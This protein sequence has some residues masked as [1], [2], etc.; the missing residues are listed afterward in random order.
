M[1][2]LSPPPLFPSFGW[3]LV[4]DA[5]LISH[6]TDCFF[7]NLDSIETS[8]SA[9]PSPQSTNFEPTVRGDIDITTGVVKKLNHNASERDRRK[10][11]NNLYSSL[12]SLLP[13]AD[14]MK[15]QSIPATVE[16]VVKYIPELKNE[17]ES[18]VQKKEELSSRMCRQREDNADY[19]V[20]K[21]RK[22]ERKE[23]SSSASVTISPVGCNEV[24]VQI[25]S[26]KADKGLL[27]EALNKL[28]LGDGLFLFN[29]SSFQSVGDIAFHSL[30]FQAQRKC[31]LE[32]EALKGK[33]MA[34]YEK[35]V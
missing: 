12:F 33:I 18:L 24:V 19:Q 5:N 25:S 4:D 34:L 29:A 15:K 16:C 23:T 9:L 17:V 21:R 28:E 13:D 20:G 3:P 11:I 6:E 2:T 32:L 8:F 1:L 30:H 35:N 26:L 14:R 10:K 7:A 31:G 22:V 27:S